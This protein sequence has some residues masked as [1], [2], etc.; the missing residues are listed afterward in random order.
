[1]GSE[2]SRAKKP[3]EEKIEE[4]MSKCNSALLKL[5]MS[6][7][8]LS[9]KRNTARVDSVAAYKRNDRVLAVELLKQ[10]DAHDAELK[11]LRGQL[12]AVEQQRSLIEQQQRNTMLTQVLVDTSAALHTAHATAAPGQSAEVVQAACDQMEEVADAQAEVLNSHLDFGEATKRAAESL[13]SPE[14]DLEESFSDE[15]ARLE[16][17]LANEPVRVEAP[18]RKPP[19]PEAMPSVPSTNLPAAPSVPA[20]SDQQP[21]VLI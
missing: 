11:V 9:T 16:A 12:Q 5:N 4:A 6:V 1:M 19:P 13:T 8:M 10:A 15:L 20:R 7:S 3:H 18:K 2:S 21:K 17:M 14:D